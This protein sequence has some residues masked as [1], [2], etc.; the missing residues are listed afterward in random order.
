M[1]A[2]APSRLLILLLALLLAGA[3]G[4]V[5]AATGAKAKTKVNTKL[6]GTFDNW[7]AYSYEESGQ[8]VC[9]M[10]SKAKKSVPKNKPRGDTYILIT[11][12]P[13]EKSF[14]VFSVTA[15]YTYKK[16][17]PVTLKVGHHPFKLFTEADT[18]WASD[19]KTDRAIASAIRGARSMVVKGT[20]ERGTETTDDYSL[21][22]SDDAFEAI[23]K[24]CGVKK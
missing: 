17:A 3:A 16:G 9:Y 6:L 14:N 4:P 24:A 10:S 22:G 15:G 2:F 12:R 19:E 18:A 8:K 1:I 11:H 23:D 21:A 7:T 13:A 5:D 20:S